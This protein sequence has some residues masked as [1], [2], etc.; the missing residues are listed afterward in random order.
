[1]NR[2]QLTVIETKFLRWP[3]WQKCEKNRKALMFSAF[4]FLHVA[5]Y[6]KEWKKKPKF[7]WL[8]RWTKKTFQISRKR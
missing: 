1:M 5:D 6:G 3:M 2:F 8:I 4:L 7:R